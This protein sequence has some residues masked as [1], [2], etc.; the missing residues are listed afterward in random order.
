MKA[1]PI[2]RKALDAVRRLL[3]WEDA[4]DQA[5]PQEDLGGLLWGPGPDGGVFL[6]PGRV[7]V[8]L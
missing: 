5:V 8:A 2:V 3:L 4:A 1:R 7:H 6:V